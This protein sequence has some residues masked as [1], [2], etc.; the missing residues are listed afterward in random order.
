MK[1]Y[2]V[3][4]P[5]FIQRIFPER[6]WAFPNHKKEVYLTFDDG[7]ISEVTPWVLSVLKKHQ[8][9]ATFFCI[10]ENI[11]K[12]PE[13]FQQLISEGHS[14]GNHT[15]NHLNG[16]KSI[17]KKYIENCVAFEDI[18][19][20]ALNDNLNSNH[21]PKP[22]NPNFAL[23]TQNSKLFRPPYGRI[24]S[25]QAKTLQ[26]KEYKII[27]WDVL[28]ADFDQN[29]S[30]EKCLKNVISNLQNGSIIVFHD[31][32]KAEKKI[33]FVLPRVLEYLDENGYC[34]KAIR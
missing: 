28:S 33:R 6:V 24:S 12:Y 10:G 27:M 23:L 31:S 4:T 8:A 11:K 19:R 34:C 25:K 29:I 17:T 26:Q 30:E 1:P 32:L 21:K 16:W 5:K 3:K 2:L 22:S 13:I 7:P 18:L 20:Y 9:K 14:F 15:F